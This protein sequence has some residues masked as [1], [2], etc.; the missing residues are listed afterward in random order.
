MALFPPCLEFTLKREGGYSFNPQ[1]PGGATNMGITRATLS[2][3]LQRNASVDEVKRLTKDVVGQIYHD[4]YWLTIDGDDLP[5]G[6][7]LLVFDHGVNCGDKESAIELQVTIG[8]TGFAVNGIIDD[9][10]ERI[11]KTRSPKYVIEALAI[12]QEAHYRSLVKFPVFGNGW[13]NRLAL[14][15]AEALRMAGV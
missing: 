4:W 15:K 7:A 10:V 3:W 5:E 2:R 9:E 12:E 13:L 1:D 14:R 8:M 11:L 6:I